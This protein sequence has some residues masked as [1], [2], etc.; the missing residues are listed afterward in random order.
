VI[1]GICPE[2]R[3]VASVSKNICSM[4]PLSC[5][6]LQLVMRSAPF[7]IEVFPV[8]VWA[9]HNVWVPAPV[10]VRIV[11]FSLAPLLRSHGSGGQCG[12]KKI[13]SLGTDV[14]DNQVPEAQK[15]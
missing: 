2:V 12:K 11:A 4:P 8:N 14:F 6:P 7:W 15:L 1:C 9:S 10:F 13:I 3:H 5:L